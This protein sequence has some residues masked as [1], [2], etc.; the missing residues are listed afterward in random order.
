[1]GLDDGAGAGVAGDESQLGED[2]AVEKDGIADAVRVVRRDNWRARLVP[3]GDERVD[4][5][6]V[7][8]GL[9][10]ED[11]EGGFCLRG[12]GSEAGPQRRALAEGGV[13]VDDDAQREI[14]DGGGDRLGFVADH[15]DHIIERRGNDAAHRGAQEWLVAKR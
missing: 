7:D 14:G 13:G 12:Q 6:R 8:A 3:G 5:P 11:E 15:D 4:D 9:V 1:M 2:A 10:A